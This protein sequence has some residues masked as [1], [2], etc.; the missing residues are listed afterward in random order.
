MSESNTSTTVTTCRRS[1]RWLWVAIP[2]VGLVAASVV[3]A[4][5]HRSPW[6]GRHGMFDSD[7]ARQRVDFAVAWVLDSIDADQTQT[8]AIQDMLGEAADELAPLAAAHRDN[9]DRIHQQ[10]RAETIDRQALE[11]IRQ[12]ELALAEEASRLLVN[13]IAD[14]AEQ[15]DEEQRIALFERLHRFHG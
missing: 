12:A 4:H 2:L 9:R 5:G 10:L 8:A 14:V 15:L 6:S 13:A 1:H 3:M 7:S 11:E